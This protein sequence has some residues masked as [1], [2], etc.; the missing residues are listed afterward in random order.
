MSLVSENS[1]TAKP[2]VK[3]LV[4][5][6]VD[7][8]LQG[9]DFMIGD[10]A[11]LKYHLNKM[12]W[13]NKEH[14]WSTV[15]L[16]LYCRTSGF[17]DIKFRT[18][19]SEKVVY[20]RFEAGHRDD[21]YFIKNYK[22]LNG[23][24]TNWMSHAATHS[25]PNDIINIILITHG[26]SASGAVQIG[27][28]LVTPKVM[29]Q[30]LSWFKEETQ[31][32]LVTNSCGGGLLGIELSKQNQK[33]RMIVAASG[34]YELTAGNGAIGWERTR[35]VSGRWRSSYFTEVLIKSLGKINL[36]ALSPNLLG[37]TVEQFEKDLYEGVFVKPTPEQSTPSVVT[38]S[39]TQKD[40]LLQV[41][42]RLQLDY[43]DFPFNR[44]RVARLLRDESDIDIIT[45]V[46]QAGLPIDDLG[47]GSLVDD[48]VL[49]EFGK[50]SSKW[51]HGVDAL[52][53]SAYTIYERGWTKQV[54]K[55]DLFLRI[56]IQ[57]KFQSAYL[58]IF[59]HLVDLGL[60]DPSCVL[61]PANV[62]SVKNEQ[63]DRVSQALETIA[64][65][66]V[67]I[68]Y[69][70]NRICAN[71]TRTWCTTIQACRHSLSHSDIR[72]QIIG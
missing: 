50:T 65:L 5:L 16:S 46:R 2:N 40:A 52:F 21:T 60:L 70:R 67:D 71:F 44:A 32:N 29:H 23:D 28:E 10:F 35:S 7:P 69:L 51:F 38:D 33:N 31:V 54:T 26:K 27:N 59:L 13:I 68:V 57:V 62:R 39:A 66:K 36:F 53:E 42:L 17:S 11:G 37:L 34:Q 48:F 41:Q 64:W 58:E 9:N 30:R 25:Q 14:F 61:L 8:T 4:I 72:S 1:A 18:A 6:A 3:L 63:V 20:S 47:F 55:A 19:E 24:L 22:T 12:G 56:W 49:H 45:R 15:D 43:Q